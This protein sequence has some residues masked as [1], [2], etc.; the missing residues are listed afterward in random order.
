MQSGKFPNI[1][2]Y[3][4]CNMPGRSEV[5]KNQLWK[6]QV[7]NVVEDLNSIYTQMQYIFWY[8]LDG[9]KESRQKWGISSAIIW[10]IVRDSRTK[11]TKV[12]KDS[13]TMY[14]V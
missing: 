13:V 6:F 7:A 14:T 4:E 9:L 10:N 11:K 1:N 12:V 8:L 3:A 5:F 2:K